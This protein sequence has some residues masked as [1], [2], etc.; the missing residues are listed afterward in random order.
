MDGTQTTYW[1]DNNN[2]AC[3]YKIEKNDKEILRIQQLDSQNT[4]Y[5][6]G[7]T[8]YKTSVEK[9]NIY[10]APQIIKTSVYDD[11][12]DDG[13]DEW[14]EVKKFGFS[15]EYDNILGV[16]KKKNNSDSSLEYNFIQKIILSFILI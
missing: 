11:Q 4:K 10:T 3:G 12:K 6:I 13:K 5:V 1:Y 2:D 16:V 15:Y 7:N 9:N 8:H 14:K